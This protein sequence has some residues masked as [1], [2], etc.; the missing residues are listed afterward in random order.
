MRKTRYFITRHFYTMVMRTNQSSTEVIELDYYRDEDG[1]TVMPWF[2]TRHEMA[3]NLVS[4]HIM[5]PRIFL[6]ECRGTN[7]KLRY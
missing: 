7:E 5:F 4:V 2:M 6:V 1:L 3:S